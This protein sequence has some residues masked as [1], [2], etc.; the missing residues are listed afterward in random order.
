MKCRDGIKDVRLG[1]GRGRDSEIS[2]CVRLVFILT[3]QNSKLFGKNKTFTVLY[4]LFWLL[5]YLEIY[6]N[7]LRRSVYPFVDK[8][9]FAILFI[10]SSITK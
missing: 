10:F 8:V 2:F 5:F 6:N 7:V 9:L 4:V 1:G 3:R